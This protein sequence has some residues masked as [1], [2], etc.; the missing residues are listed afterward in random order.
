MI[1][2]DL[3]SL[4][5]YAESCRKI[6]E[7]EFPGLTIEAVKNLE[8][9]YNAYPGLDKLES[10][11]NQIVL[12]S[13]LNDK[14]RSEAQKAILEGRIFWEYTAAGEATRLA[15]GPKYLIAPHNIPTD[16]QKLLPYVLGD[17]YLGQWAFEINNLALAAG[18]DP[19]EVL[20]RQTILL[21]I[22][23][24]SRI[25]IIRHVQNAAFLGL[26]PKNFLFMIQAS[27]PA[28]RPEGG[29]H[30]DENT[31]YHLHNHGQMAM[32]K[33]MD[34]QIWYIGVDGQK[35]YLRQSDFFERLARH[36]DLVSY[37]I[38]DLNYLNKA[39]DFDTIGLALHLG[40]AGFNMTMEIVPNNPERPIKGGFCA[41]DPALNRDVIIETFRLHHLPPEKITHLNKNFNHYP[42]PT[43]VF[44]R[45]TEEGLFMPVVVK[46]GGLYFQPVQGDINFLTSTAFIIRQNPIPLSGWKSPEDTSVALTALAQ[47]DAQ[48]NFATF[49]ATRINIQ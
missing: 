41:Y 20:A 29:W 39:L 38:E 9:E 21:I 25:E 1:K 40:R 17:R 12:E 46:D 10:P 45:L 27:F 2:I 44:K 5:T 15:L 35:N 37:N 47:Q 32:Q 49:M 7:A 33:T 28:L 23:E 19:R 30:F 8:D 22:N 34:N 26:A 42:N 48:I 16:K 43:Q 4:A 18:L 36:D 31:P 24:S 14:I 3:T 6:A 13:C 11:H